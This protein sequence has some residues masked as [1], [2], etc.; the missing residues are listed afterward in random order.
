MIFSNYQPTVKPIVP[1]AEN[2]ETSK[3]QGET[4]EKE[5]TFTP[6]KNKATYIGKDDEVIEVEKSVPMNPEKYTI[7]GLIGMFKSR[8]KQR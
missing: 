5:I 3:P 4:Q 7:L 6:G 8:K 1:T 2:G